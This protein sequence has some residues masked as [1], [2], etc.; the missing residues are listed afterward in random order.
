MADLKGGDLARNRQIL[1]ELAEG[2]ATRG[3]TDTV[4]MN[5]G[6]A[7]WVAGRADSPRA[8]IVQAQTQLTEGGFRQWLTRFKEDLA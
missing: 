4:A 3:P 2:R 1:E 7:L 6:V 5:A 8:G